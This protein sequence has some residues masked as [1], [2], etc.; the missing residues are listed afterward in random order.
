MEI[1]NV[2]KK[3][4]YFLSGFLF[5]RACHFERHIVPELKS[6]SEKIK[7]ALEIGCSALRFDA[8]LMTG[9]EFNGSHDHAGRAAVNARLVL[10]LN[11]LL[12]HRAFLRIV[13]LQKE[14]MQ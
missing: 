11:F 10:N 13:L 7:N 2:L 6:E 4:R 14:N 8:E 1:V 5:L 3:F 12:K 9:I